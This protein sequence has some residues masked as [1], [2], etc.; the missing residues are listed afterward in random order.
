M[1]KYPSLDKIRD[2]R[3]TIFTNCIVALDGV[4][5]CFI[6][7]SYELWNK[8]WESL[9][10]QIRIGRPQQK[11]MSLFV[12]GFD[13]FTLTAYFNLLFIALENGFRVFYKPV[14][15]SKNVPDAFYDVY[16]NIL[17]DLQLSRYLDLTWSKEAR[18]LEQHYSRRF[19][20]TSAL[21]KN[22]IIASVVFSKPYNTS[23]FS[24]SKVGVLVAGNNIC[25]HQ[26]LY[27]RYFSLNNQISNSNSCWTDK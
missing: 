9:N 4:F 24:E 6:V 26:L 17:L 8:W 13:S 1:D 15:S 7:R 14:F 3:I 23:V 22:F 16:K 2:A 11:D 10:K 18:S 5:I 12:H 19:I 21:F 20:E 27:K 25:Y